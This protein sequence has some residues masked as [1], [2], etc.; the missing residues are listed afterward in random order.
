M[1]PTVSRELRLHGDTQKAVRGVPE[2]GCRVGDGGVVARVLGWES[3]S[4]SR[5]PASAALSATQSR[6]P[7]QSV[8][9]ALHRAG[10]RVP[11][12]VA[13]GGFDG[14]PLARLTEPP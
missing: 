13:W 12:D 5:L 9:K 4:A 3:W 2:R 14:I 7:E 6:D 1:L 10:R 8:S 11:D